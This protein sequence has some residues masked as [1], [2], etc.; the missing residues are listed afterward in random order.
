MRIAVIGAGNGGQAISAYLAS[1]GAEVRLYDYDG[2]KV[3]QLNGKDNQIELCGCIQT[4]ARISLISDD[5]ESVVRNAEMILITTTAN[6]HG[7]IAKRVAPFLEDGQV[8]ILNPGRTGGALEFK[9]VI[10]RD[11]PGTSVYVAEAQ[12]LVYACRLIEN[13]KVNIIGVKDNVLLSALPS[14]DTPHVLSKIGRYYDCFLPAENVIRTSLE[15]IGA[16]FHPSILLF[17]AATIERQNE[18]WFYRDVTPQVADFVER[19][20]AER[21]AVGKA[22]GIELLGVSDWI[23]FAYPET[24]GDTLCEKMIDNPAYRDIK[25]PPTIFT[26]QL[27]EDIPTGVLP[28]MEL[29]RAAGLQMP[30]MSAM[31]D[32]CSALLGMD[33]REGGRT[34]ESLGLKGKDIDDIIKYLS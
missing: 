20:D 18:F 5:L 28:M 22:F 2:Q 32:I 29:G 9:N 12:T 16:V 21:L 17:N 10:M 3:R 30:L 6:A 27:T 11:N 26:R 8:I 13:G 24:K 4:K 7:I 34:L 19:F 1:E 31:V 23:S 33:F 14:S 25:S 15:N